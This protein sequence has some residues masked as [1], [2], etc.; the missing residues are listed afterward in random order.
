MCPVVKK[1]NHGSGKKSQDLR[2]LAAL[3]E[4]LGLY[5]NKSLTNKT[6]IK[7]ILVSIFYLVKVH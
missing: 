2:I 3:A 4:N 1:N 5:P 6:I 7:Q